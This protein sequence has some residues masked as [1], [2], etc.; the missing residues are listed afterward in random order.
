[1]R[2]N[3]PG[4]ANQSHVGGLDL[5]GGAA[6]AAVVRLVQQARLGV[7]PSVSP[8]LYFFKSFVD[9]FCFVCPF[10]DVLFF[11]FPYMFFVFA[12]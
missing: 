10:V 12:L 9:L 7:F 5:K 1:M 6:S 11:S 2:C 4:G 3:H 8:M